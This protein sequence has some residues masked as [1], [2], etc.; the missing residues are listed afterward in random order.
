MSG[1]DIFKLP[2]WRRDE[3]FEQVL[4][5]YLDKKVRQTWQS[6]LKRHCSQVSICICKNHCYELVFSIYKV[7]RGDFWEKQLDQ[8]DDG[9]EAEADEGLQEAPGA[10]IH[11]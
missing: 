7:P 8:D 4:T 9:S 2:R 6:L 5:K 10:Q 1:E 11:L 3:N